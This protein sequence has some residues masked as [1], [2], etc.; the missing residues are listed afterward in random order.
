MRRKVFHYPSQ[1]QRQAQVPR[2]AETWK[3]GVFVS[4]RHIRALVDTIREE[5]A[6]SIRKLLEP[7]LNGIDAECSRLLEEYPD[8]L[9]SGKN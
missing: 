2:V 4:A 3:L 9:D 6:P 5:T 1:G 8:E 7:A